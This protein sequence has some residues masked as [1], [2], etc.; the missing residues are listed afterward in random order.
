MNDAASTPSSP[1]APSPLAG[2]ALVDISPENAQQALV[3]ESSLRPVLVQFWS[4]RSEPCLQL[5]STLEL[6]AQEY[7]GK[8]LLA[9]V[10]ADSQEGQMI[11]GQLGVR[12]LPTIMV[13]QDGQPVDGLT[14]PQEEPALRELL[15]KYL[16]KP[17]DDQLQQAQ[18]LL[19]DG[20]LNEALALLRPAYED[21]AQ[22]VDIALVLAHVYLELNRCDDAETVLGQIKLADQDASYAQLMSQLELK[23]EAAQSPEVQAL[24]AAVAQ[25]ADDHAAAY[26]LAIQYS[27]L[28]KY[29]DA[30]ELLLLILRKD[31]QFEEGAAKKAY[32]DIL[33][34][35][36][37][38]EALAV[39]YQRK[40]FA[41]L[42]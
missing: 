40:L 35:L 23:R 10:N 22:R 9:R 20:Q 30:L 12:S 25:S 21:S 32:Q 14:G 3:A 13:M 11:A 29:G 5:K 31:M 26:Q 34:S 2:L 8:F 18:A 42:Y 7:S 24:E 38:G 37:K 41:L 27:Q 19:V 15:D 17:W 1:A 33:A 6:L 39:Q 4:E 16:P 36:G 28:G